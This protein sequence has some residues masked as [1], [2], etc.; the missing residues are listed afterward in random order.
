MVFQGSMG[1]ANAVG[2]LVMQRSLAL[3]RL[4]PLVASIAGVAGSLALRRHIPHH[5]A[6]SA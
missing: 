6:I 4:V 3:V 1:V 2:G 5:V